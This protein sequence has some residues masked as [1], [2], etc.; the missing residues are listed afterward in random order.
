MHTQL[1]IHICPETQ[2]TNTHTE[3]LSTNKQ[4]GSAVTSLTC[5]Y[6]LT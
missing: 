5:T 2:Q 3:L 4:P 1:Y 6:M